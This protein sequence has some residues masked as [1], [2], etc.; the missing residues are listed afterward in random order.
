M[1]PLE[2]KSGPPSQDPEDRTVRP[3]GHKGTFKRIGKDSAADQQQ[4]PCRG[5]HPKRKRSEEENL[6]ETMVK[7]DGPSQIPLRCAPSSIIMGFDLNK[8]SPCIIGFH[9]AKCPNSD[10]QGG[11]FFAPETNMI[12]A[13][14]VGASFV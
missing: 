4:A 2:I 8:I 5:K 1:D 13:D 7:L 6:S 12:F 10:S 9:W 14:G 11:L 3:T